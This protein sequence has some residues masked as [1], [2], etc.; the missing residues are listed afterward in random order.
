M[1]VLFNLNS[2]FPHQQ[3][4]RKQLDKLSYAFT[5]SISDFEEHESIN[6]LSIEDNEENK[7]QQKHQLDSAN[8]YSN[9]VTKIVKQILTKRTTKST[10][11]R[12]RKH[13]EQIEENDLIKSSIVDK[14][15]KLL[16]ELTLKRLKPAF[17]LQL[18]DM[19]PEEQ[20]ELVNDINKIINENGSG[21][22][23]SKDG[24]R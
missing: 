22:R 11:F 4:N 21:F 10:E 13:V 5:D 19:T 1:F 20:D 15:F 12:R 23:S 6:G 18:P 7:F 3:L 2:A 24:K 8:K 16:S 14:K 17:E 9:L